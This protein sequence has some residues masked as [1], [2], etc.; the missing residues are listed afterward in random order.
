MT[1]SRQLQLL[2]VEYSNG[3]FQ[4]A[5]QLADALVVSSD[6]DSERMMAW[7]FK[8]LSAAAMSTINQQRLTN[9]VSYFREA[10][11]HNSD[12]GALTPSAIQLSSWTLSHAK[13]LLTQYDAESDNQLAGRRGS[14][15]HNPNE[16]LGQYAGRELGQALFDIAESANRRRK[17]A[18]TLGQHFESNHSAAIVAALDYSYSASGQSAEVARN[19][20]DVT[21][22]VTSMVAI[23]PGS[24]RR[25]IA[26]IEPLRS[27]I[28]KKHSDLLFYTVKD[29]DEVMCPNCGYTLVKPKP[30]FF[31][32]IFSSYVKKAKRGQ[33]LFCATC[34][35]EWKY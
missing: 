34:A 11:K 29:T 19:T 4:R 31:G 35:H 26:A 6:D 28:W 7:L 8:G 13:Q 18:V 15:K 1:M 9:A 10:Q 22:A 5:S 20:A 16:D 30:G 21:D 33:Q 32:G 25:F 2:Q 3:N 14:V 17:I 27:Q 24:R 12:P 23:M